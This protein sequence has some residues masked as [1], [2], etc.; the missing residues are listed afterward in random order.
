MEPFPG[1]VILLLN[2]NH[3]DAAQE[4]Y[5]KY[6]SSALYGSNDKLVEAG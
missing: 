3:T 5:L 4:A 1:S 2:L 6:P